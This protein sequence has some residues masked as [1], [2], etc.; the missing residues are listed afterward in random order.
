MGMNPD[1]IG[2]VYPPSQPYSVTAEK[3]SAFVKALGDTN[4]AYAD[5]TVAP[6]TF[7]IVVTMNAMDTAF[8]DPALRLDYSRLVH[9]DQ[10]FEYLR[11]IRVGDELTV[12]ASVEE[13]KPLGTN[14]IATFKTDVF[15]GGELV[16][17]GWSKIVV[18]GPEA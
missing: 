12:R 9:S 18:R 8:H 7:S 6:P 13:I 15:S 16:V 3:I 4:P 10:K 17:T 5:G 14:E 1:M 2:H 11:P